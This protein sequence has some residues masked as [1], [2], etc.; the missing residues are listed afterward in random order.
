MIIVDI[1]HG[2]RSGLLRSFIQ[3]IAEVD[4]LQGNDRPRS[5]EL[6]KTSYILSSAKRMR[7]H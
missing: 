4:I 3:E 5:R 2:V 1:I 6:V 7:K